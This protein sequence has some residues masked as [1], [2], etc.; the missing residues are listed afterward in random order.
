MKWI[1]FV[2]SGHYLGLLKQSQYTTIQNIFYIF[3]CYSFLIWFLTWTV[4]FSL[5]DVPG[6]LFFSW[7]VCPLVNDIKLDLLPVSPL[8]CT[9]S[10]LCSTKRHAINP[11]YHCLHSAGST[12]QQLP[13]VPPL[14]PWTSHL[15]CV[16]LYSQ[17]TKRSA[18]YLIDALTSVDVISEDDF[19]CNRVACV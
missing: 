16:I 17:A 5:I 12:N 7:S 14:F 10:Q 6:L 13:R 9:E 18:T 8:F 1:R 19:L 2:K 3:H 15:V 4:M 11:E